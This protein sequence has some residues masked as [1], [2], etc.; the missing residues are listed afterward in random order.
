MFFS[1]SKSQVSLNSLFVFTL[2]LLNVVQSVFCAILTRGMYAQFKSGYLFIQSVPAKFKVSRPVLGDF[3][4]PSSSQRWN[5]F[6]HGL[7]TRKASGRFSH[8]LVHLGPFGFVCGWTW[9]EYISIYIQLSLYWAI[10]GH[11]GSG[12]SFSVRNSGVWDKRWL[13]ITCN[14]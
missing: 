5:I 11:W 4:P 8:I 13:L 2:V 1:A 10:G 6:F 7:P 14:K 9:W 3:A 12:T